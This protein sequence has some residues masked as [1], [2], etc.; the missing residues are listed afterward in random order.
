MPTRQPAIINDCPRLP[1]VSPRQ[2]YLIWLSG[3]SLCSR[4]VITS[5]TSC[6][7]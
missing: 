5:A 4:I 2:A 6:V 7:G 3:L 1:R